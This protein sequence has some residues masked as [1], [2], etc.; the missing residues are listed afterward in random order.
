MQPSV[1]T[2]CAHNPSFYKREND[3]IL[4]CKSCFK[5]SIERRVRRTIS[6][7]HMFA[8]RDHIAVAVSGGKDSVTLLT[9]L[10]KLTSK[11]PLTKITAVTVDEGI[12]GYREEAVDIASS[13]C[14]KLGVEHLVLSFADLYGAGLDDFLRAKHDRMTACSYCGV[15]RRKAINMV[16]RR[17]NATKIVTAHNLDDMVQTYLLNLFQGDVTRFARFSPVLKDSQRRFLPRLKPLCEIPE[18]EVAL[19]AYAEG[20]EFQTASCPYMTE[21]LRNELRSMVN[22]LELAHPGL[23]FSSY[24]AMTR[25][26]SMAERNVSQA[27]LRECIS[28]G[29]PTPFETCE[30]CKMQG[31]MGKLLQVGS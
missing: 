8:P 10:K 6:Y 21:A 29:E 22:R 26:R 13:Y 31:P 19:Y 18:R 1:C 5:G 30:A 11:F 23:L 25:L 20:L 3:A 27:E 28:C 4:L 9:I 15:F 16:A 24:R 2:V 7:W 12:E 14:K 17:V